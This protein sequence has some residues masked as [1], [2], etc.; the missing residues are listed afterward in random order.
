MKVNNP[1]NYSKRT[2]AQVKS[3]LKA[4]GADVFVENLGDGRSFWV[5]LPSTLKNRVALKKMGFL[6]ARSEDGDKSIIIRTY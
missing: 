5:G 6:L 2:V 1:D 3:I 4:N